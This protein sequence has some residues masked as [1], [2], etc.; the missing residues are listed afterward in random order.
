MEDRVLN[1]IINRQSARLLS[2]LETLGKVKDDETKNIIKKY[3]NFAKFD[4]EEYINKIKAYQ[5]YR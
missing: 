5:L 2:E 3:F 4:I 1:K